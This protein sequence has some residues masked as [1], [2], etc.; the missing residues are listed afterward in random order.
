MPNRIVPEE[1]NSL[2]VKTGGFNGLEGE[3]CEGAGDGKEL[4]DLSVGAEMVILLDVV[5]V[6]ELGGGTRAFVTSSRPFSK[7]R[8]RAL[9]SSF[10][11]TF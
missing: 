10:S 7:V 6:V 9:S 8:I 3:S 11:R 1:K 2:G 4:G 5:R